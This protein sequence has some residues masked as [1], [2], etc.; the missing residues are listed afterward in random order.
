LGI[1]YWGV[2]SIPHDG[3]IN[4]LKDEDLQT[5]I[6]TTQCVYAKKVKM[7]WDHIY[8]EQRCNKKIQKQ[9]INT[10]IDFHGS[11]MIHG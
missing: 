6:Y 10:I 5:F 4:A 3:P 1:K 11:K 9:Q 8:W 7:A 2:R